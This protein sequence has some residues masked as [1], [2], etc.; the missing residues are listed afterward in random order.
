M[1]SKN[2]SSITEQL[3]NEKFSMHNFLKFISVGRILDTAVGNF[4]AMAFTALVSSMVMDILTPLLGALVNRNIQTWYLVVRSGSKA[5]Y[6]TLESAM[7][8]EEAI[9]LRYG[10]VI[11]AL[12]QF[13]V[14]SMVIYFVLKAL[15]TAQSVISKKVPFT[16]Q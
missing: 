13:I 5:P 1:A 15:I 12:I 3:A 7:D 10:R 4:M 6:D 8:D 14:Q 16:S 11:H 2:V 9:V